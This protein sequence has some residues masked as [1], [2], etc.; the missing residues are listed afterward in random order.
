MLTIASTIA[1]AVSCDLPGEL[2]PSTPAHCE[3]RYRVP[4]TPHARRRP[5]AAIP[6][7][8]EGTHPSYVRGFLPPAYVQPRPTEAYGGSIRNEPINDQGHPASE[9][10]GKF[11][12]GTFSSRVRCSRPISLPAFAAHAPQTH[13]V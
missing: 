5:T 13:L 11:L 2:L 10:S 12:S 6:R 3:A 1:Q 4:A 9:L 8:D 7:V